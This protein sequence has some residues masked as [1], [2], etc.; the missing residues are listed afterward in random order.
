MAYHHHSDIIRVT[1]PRYLGNFDRIMIERFIISKSIIRSK[2]IPGRISESFVYPKSQIHVKMYPWE[3]KTRKTKIIYMRLIDLYKAF[4]FI[5]RTTMFYLTVIKLAKRGCSFKF[6]RLND[7]LCNI[8][9][10]AMERHQRRDSSEDEYSAIRRPVP[11]ACPQ[12]TL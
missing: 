4:D 12:F 3:P 5:W 6:L 7:G 2:Q 8:I 11:H 1:L 9:N 10:D